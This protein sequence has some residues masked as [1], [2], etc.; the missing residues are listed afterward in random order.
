M[1]VQAL[2][3]GNP[4]NQ[5]C[6]V[7]YIGM[8]I[9]KEHIEYLKDNPEGYWFKR[10]LYGWGWIPATREGWG[11]LAL[12][13]AAIIA[14]AFTIDENSPPREIVFTFVF[15]VAVLTLLLI[16]ICYKTGEKPKWMWGPP[17]KTDEK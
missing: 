4:P 13:L 9:I 3:I 10:R 11:I 17:K 6:G 16:R 5:F 2:A 1:V 15:P 7:L 14:F 8:N 12:Y